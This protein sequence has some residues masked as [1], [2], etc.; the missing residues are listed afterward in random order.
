[1]S[2]ILSHTSKL[3]FF[4][5]CNTK[6]KQYLAEESDWRVHFGVFCM[7]RLVTVWQQKR[8]QLASMYTR[9]CAVFLSFIDYVVYK[10]IVWLFYIAIET[11]QISWE[12]H[13]IKTNCLFLSTAWTMQW[14]SSTWIHRR[15]AWKFWYWCKW[16]NVLK[17][18]TF[19]C[20]WVSDAYDEK[21]LNGSTAQQLINLMK[22][23]PMFLLTLTVYTIH[24]YVCIICEKMRASLLNE[25][26]L[27]LH[28]LYLI[29]KKIIALRMLSNLC[30]R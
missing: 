23:L 16:F 7:L 12:N 2:S 15:G 27:D 22:S 21:W 11:R 13:M 4:E 26:H 30:Y 28:S 6:Q 18:C 24:M 14:K 20:E 25:C 10:T 19:V 5:A 3:I 1:M 8:S 29:A 17:M 9:A